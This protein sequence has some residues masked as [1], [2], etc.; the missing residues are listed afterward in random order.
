METPGGEIF[1]HARGNFVV[2][3]HGASIHFTCAT[4]YIHANAAAA[5]GRDKRRERQNVK[6]T[7]GKRET[8]RTTKT[9]W[10]EIREVA[11]VTSAGRCLSAAP[12]TEPLERI[13]MALSRASSS[14]ARRDL[15]GLCRI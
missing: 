1:L 9:L 4:L 8:E 3:S 12:E 10:K 7:S 11:G 13:S 6:N 2:L 14:S 15:R 5:R